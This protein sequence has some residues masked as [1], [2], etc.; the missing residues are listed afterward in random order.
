MKL[1]KDDLSKLAIKY[2][3]KTEGA[4]FNPS[5]N[6]FEKQLLEESSHF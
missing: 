1:N 5:S 6:T 3:N 4:Y 2:A